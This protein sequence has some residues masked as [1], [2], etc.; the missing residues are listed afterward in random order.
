M[1]KCYSSL[2]YLLR[3]LKILKQFIYNFI[4]YT[5]LVMTEFLLIS[6]P[7]PRKSSKLRHILFDQKRGKKIKD[8][9]KQGARVFVRYI[10]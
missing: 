9:G 3:F 2:L 5:I 7:P 6:S 10:E 1:K 8:G 4:V